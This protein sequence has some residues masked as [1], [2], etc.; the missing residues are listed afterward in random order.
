MNLLICKPGIAE[1]GEGKP[2]VW[3]TWPSSR[4][5][6]APGVSV[7]GS[8]FPC[9]SLPLLNSETCLWLVR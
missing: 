2:P 3:A 8:A 6:V 1:C 5:A 7:D 4:L 9:F